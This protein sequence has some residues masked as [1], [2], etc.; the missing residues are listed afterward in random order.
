MVLGSPPGLH[1]ILIPCLVVC[2]LECC[3]DALI[4]SASP[5]WRRGGFFSWTELVSFLTIV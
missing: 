5:C 1:L 2:S 4:H 3:Q